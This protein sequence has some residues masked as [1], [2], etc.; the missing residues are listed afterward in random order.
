MA[1]AADRF[2]FAPRRE[3]L[4]ATRWLVLAAVAGLA[5]GA[6]PSPV[7]AHPPNVVL[8]LADNLGYGEVACNGSSRMVPTPRIDR[9]A[10][11]GLRLTNFNVESECVPSRAAL[12]T[13]RF[14][15]R[16]GAL[17]SAP[18][19]QPQGLTAWEVTLAELLSARGY[20]TACHGKWHLGDTP[21]R[22]PTDRGFDE[23]YGIPRSSDEA[24]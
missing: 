8:I 16:S 20:A 23:W 4:M 5:L 2:P 1:V 14:P 24:N 6:G 15:I 17:K 3:Q 19:G 9:L 13:G 21:G 11:Q 22:F 10:A 18:P 7:P 12:L